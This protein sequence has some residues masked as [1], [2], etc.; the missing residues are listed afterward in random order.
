MRTHRLLSD[1]L[2]ASFSALCTFFFFIFVRLF[3]QDFAW[4]TNFWGLL[5]RQLQMFRNDEEE[6]LKGIP[7]RAAAFGERQ[8]WIFSE[9]HLWAFGLKDLPCKSGRVTDV[10]LFPIVRCGLSGRVFSRQEE[11]YRRGLAF[12]SC[13]ETEAFFALAYKRKLQWRFLLLFL[14][15]ER[16]GAY[17]RFCRLSCCPIRAFCGQ[18]ENDLRS[19]G[20]L[21]YWFSQT[22]QRRRKKWKF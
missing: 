7:Q 22:T 11:W 19:T 4:Q 16:P 20:W 18:R 17:D 2:P 6:Y 13:M 10:I 12:V 9:N 14:L 15:T 8:C 1:V 5:Y 21:D 3:I